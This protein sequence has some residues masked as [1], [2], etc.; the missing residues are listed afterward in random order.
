MSTETL[1]R[2]AV[3]TTGLF[4]GAALYVGWVQVYI[5]FLLKHTHDEHDE[6]RVFNDE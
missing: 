4:A 5:Q 3:A 6:Q 1:Y 2:V